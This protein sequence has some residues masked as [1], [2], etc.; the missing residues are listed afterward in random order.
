MAGENKHWSII[1]LCAKIE[2]TAWSIKTA[3]TGSKD[4]DMAVTL[5]YKGKKYENVSYYILLHSGVFR[6]GEANRSPT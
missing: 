2:T 4:E 5:L 1:L 3:K 6:N